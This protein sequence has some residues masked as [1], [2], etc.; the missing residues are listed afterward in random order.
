MKIRTQ[1]IVS[2]VFF[3]VALLIISASVMLTHQKVERLNKQEE[4]AKNIEIGASELGYLSNDYLLYHERQQVDRWEAKFSTFSRDLS[5]LGVDRPDSQ[6][7]VDN[8][9]ANRLRLREIFDD[10]VSKIESAP[11]DFGGSIGQGIYSGLG[12]PYRSSSPGNRI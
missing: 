4:L 9:K 6:V 1:L 3:G 11:Q 8:I 5:D 7:L 10:V 2:M 12:K